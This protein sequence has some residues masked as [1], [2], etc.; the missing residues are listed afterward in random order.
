MAAPSWGAVISNV[1]QS[2]FALSEAYNKSKIIDAESKLN[3]TLSG[4]EARQME[5]SAISIENRGVRAAMLEQQKTA[6]VS[7]DAVAAM[8]AGGGGVDPEMLAK[9]KQRGDYNSM[10][11]IFDA[12]TAAIDLRYQAEMTRIGSRVSA[13]SA[14][15]Y[16][17]SLEREARVGAVFNSMDLFASA[18]T[19]KA[20][21]PKPKTYATNASGGRITHGGRQQ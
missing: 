9:I 19:P 18:Y 13:G 21:S 7:S 20:K 3:Q 14:Q 5:R 12:R 1:G 10:T 4:I 15:R 6:M 2:Y 17:D 8:A 11:A 16:G